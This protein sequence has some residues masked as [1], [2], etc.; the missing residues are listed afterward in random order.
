MTAV[1][2]WT[3]HG[4]TLRPSDRLTGSVDA[5]NGTLLAGT[6][7]PIVISQP[8]GAWYGKRPGEDARRFESRQGA[9]AHILDAIYLL[10]TRGVDLY[11]TGQQ[12]L[13][14]R[15]ADLAGWTWH[16]GIEWRAR[17]VVEPFD[18]RVASEHSGIAYFVNGCPDCVCD[19]PVCRADE[20]GR[21]CEDVS[22]GFCL[23]GCSEDEHVPGVGA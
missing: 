19:L 8:G 12:V 17:W 5:F 2:P 16:I 9:F 3:T 21:H 4:I 23:H 13:G 6:A 1:D 11:D 15:G 14:Y 18:Y 20:T 22:C 7:F 10:T